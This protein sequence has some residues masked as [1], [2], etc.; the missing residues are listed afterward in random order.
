MLDV[1]F[2]EDLSRA[3]LGD[4][5]ENLALL[6]RWVLSM[7]RQDTTMKGSIKSKRRRAGWNNEILEK[8]LG[9]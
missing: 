2:D 3:R 9:L 7:L 6:R 1:E 5:Q 4:A 8:L